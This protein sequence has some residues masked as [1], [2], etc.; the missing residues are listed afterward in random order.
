M[1]ARWHR[2]A[3]DDTWLLTG[4]DEHG[5]K[6]LRTAAA[7]GTT[8]QEWADR[9]V[10]RRRGCPLLETLDVA[11]DDFIRTTAGAPR[12][13]ACSRSCRRSTTTATSTRANTRRSTA[14]AA[15]SS[16]RSARSSTATG[17]VRGPEGLRDPLASPLELL[18]EKNYFFRMSEFQDRLLEL[19]E[20]R[21]DFIQPESAR[22]EV[23]SFVKQGLKDLSISR[24]T[25]RLGHQGALGRVARHLRVV[26]R[27]AELRHRGRLRRRPR[28]SSH[29]AGP[30]TT[31]SAKTSCASTP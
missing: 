11:N 27:A 10:E 7:N 31:S 17:R 15:R 8:P 14:S 25:L 19:Y 28:S 1:L 30:R 3:G 20:E 23:V 18:Q 5:Q 4:T 29:A 6:M 12:A 24:S 2:Q 16:S 21:P 22:N 9:L 13:A 26:R